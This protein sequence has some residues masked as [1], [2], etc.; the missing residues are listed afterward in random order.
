[1]TSTPDNIQICN[2]NLV[3]RHWEEL[4]N[5]DLV[6]RVGTFY[7]ADFSNFGVPPDL[8]DIARI[9][10]AWRTAFPDLEYLVEANLAENDQVVSRC[11][12]SG[13]QSGPVPLGG[14]STL[15]PTGQHFAATQV[16]R[17]RLR[18]GQIVEHWAV[19]DDMAMLAQLGHVSPS[20]RQG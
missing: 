17:F 10:A 15:A 6:D 18:D 19:R 20:C 7:A 1:M 2:K 13:T 4:W 3:S 5:Q 12:V 9:G 16:H 11:T 8:A 14:W